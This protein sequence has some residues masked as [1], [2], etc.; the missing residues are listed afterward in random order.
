MTDVGDIF[1]DYLPVDL[2]DTPKE[3]TEQHKK[4]EELKSS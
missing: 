1:D 3:G 2:V 4:H